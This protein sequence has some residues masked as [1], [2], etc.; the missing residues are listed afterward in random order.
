MTNNPCT[1]VFR[2]GAAIFSYKRP[3]LVEPHASSSSQQ[4]DMPRN[5]RP[6]TDQSNDSEQGKQIMNDLLTVLCHQFLK[7]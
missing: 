7:K 4:E 5:K 3:K 6:R 2:E 1:Y